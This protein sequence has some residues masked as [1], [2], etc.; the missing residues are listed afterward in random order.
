[1]KNFNYKGLKV[2]ATS[3]QEVLAEI[4]SSKTK[5]KLNDEEIK[6]LS[7]NNFNSKL[8]NLIAEDKDVARIKVLYE[9]GNIIQICCIV[10]N[11]FNKKPFSFRIETFNEDDDELDSL[12]SMLSLFDG[13]SKGYVSLKDIL[14]KISAVEEKMNHIRVNMEKTNKEIKNLV[15]KY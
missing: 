1:M 3:K 4:M 15:N 13:E 8:Y 2:K 14:I 10:K 5:F 9:K 11:G 7:D 12:E 6:Q